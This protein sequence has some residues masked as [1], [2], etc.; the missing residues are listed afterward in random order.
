MTM[1]GNTLAALALLVIVFGVGQIA[2]PY[3]GK[4]RITDDAIEFVMFGNLRVWR[5]SFED[6]SDIQ[7]VSFA[8]SFVLPALHLMN[9]P[10]AQYV[11]LRRRRG[12]F[13]FVLITPDRPQELVRMVREKI[14]N[15]SA[16]G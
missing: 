3:C 10:F 16:A 11:L 2:G 6:I 12:V 13:R 1:I 9:R 14:R 15:A 7:P 8:R 5:C 4:Y